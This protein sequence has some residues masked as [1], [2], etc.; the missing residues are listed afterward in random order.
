MSEEKGRIDLF[1][2]SRLEKIRVV[3]SSEKCLLWNFLKIIAGLGGLVFNNSW[4]SGLLLKH[5][6]KVLQCLLAISFFV[7]GNKCGFFQ[8]NI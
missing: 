8:E 5:V 6:E 7:K 3:T 4:R 1:E 2:G